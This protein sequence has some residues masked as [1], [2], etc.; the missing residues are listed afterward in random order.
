MTYIPTYTENSI[1]ILLG[2]NLISMLPL[3]VYI[4]YFDRSDDG[5]W[6]GRVGYYIIKLFRSFK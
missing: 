1:L 2:F 6:L 5:A 3:L 4:S